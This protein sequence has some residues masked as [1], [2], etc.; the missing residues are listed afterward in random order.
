[1]ESFDVTALYTSMSNDSA[2]QVI[3]ELLTQ[4]EGEI[5]MHGFKIEQLMALLKKCLSCSI[6]RWPG[7]YYAQIG[8]LA[9]GQRLA[10]SLAIAFMSKV[11]TL[12]TDLGSLHYRR[13]IDDCFV[14]CSTQEEMDK[15]FEL[16]NEKSEYIKFA[17]EK[18][19]ENWLSFLNVQINLA[20]NGY[21]T[22]WYRKPSTKNILVHYLSSHPSHTKRA[23]V[24][25]M[26]QMATSVCT[27][28][29]QKE[30]SRNLVR[31]I[32]VSNGYETVAPRDRCRG[33]AK[34][35][36]DSSSDS[37]VPF[38]LPFIS[39]ELSAAKSRCLRRTGLVNSVRIVEIPPNTLK[40]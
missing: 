18:P 24:R 19:K 23:L 34:P 21:I 25:N 38:I 2:M 10:P 39:N 13:Y 40:S 35:Q 36:N 31:E 16:L 14:I 17:R 26:F 8:G 5:N 1:M 3:F 20:E 37:E 32:A 12:V 15:C 9:M 22:K 33:K 6:F 4:H 29:E 30:E 28:R 7:K 11:E 27:G